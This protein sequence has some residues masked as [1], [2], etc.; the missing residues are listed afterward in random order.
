[1]SHWTKSHCSYDSTCN[2]S[3]QI[4]STLTNSVTKR[5]SD[6]KRA[7]LAQKDRTRS[8]CLGQVERW[9][10]LAFTQ[11]SLKGIISQGF[12]GD[13]CERTEMQ[14]KSPTLWFQDSI[15]TQTHTLR[16]L[17]LIRVIPTKDIWTLNPNSR[18]LT[19]WEKNY[20]LIWSD[21]Q[22]QRKDKTSIAQQACEYYR[23][24]F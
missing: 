20:K 6:S 4:L 22:I 9:G 5:A 1:M 16:D 18:N 15:K 21:L 23:M 2:D 19:N 14:M 24:S 11:T 12:V 3:R 10:C 7:L 17:V 13:S 8:S